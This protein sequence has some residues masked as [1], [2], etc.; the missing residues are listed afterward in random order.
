MART[1]CSPPIA[2]SM[3]AAIDTTQKCRSVRPMTAIDGNPRNLPGV[4]R[5]AE[6]EPKPTLI[7][8]YILSRG[9]RMS[10]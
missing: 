2:R 3:T 7:G 4:C 10:A 5:R 6:I 8:N 1:I 9:P